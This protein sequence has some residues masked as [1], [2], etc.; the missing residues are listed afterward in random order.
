MAQPY[1]RSHPH[2]HSYPHSH[3]QPH[4]HSHFNSNPDLHTQNQTTAS[5]QEKQ[6]I[7]RVPSVGHRYNQ[8]GRSFLV[9]YGHAVHRPSMG[10]LNVRSRG[11]CRQSSARRLC[12]TFSYGFRTEF[13]VMGWW[14]KD[15]CLFKSRK[16]ESEPTDWM[17]RRRSRRNRK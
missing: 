13:G 16:R 8:P 15:G 6:H 5:H 1:P 10:R 17:N 3:P 11:I 14:L 12:S 4:S 2:P 7:F 9:I